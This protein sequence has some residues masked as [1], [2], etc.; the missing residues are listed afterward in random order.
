MLQAAGPSHPAVPRKDRMGC[1]R[2]V[3]KP[4][5]RFAISAPSE[6]WFRGNLSDSE[7]IGIKRCRAEHLRCES[8]SATSFQKIHT[9]SL[10]LSSLINSVRICLAHASLVPVQDATVLL[11]HHVLD[12]AMPPTSH[13]HPSLR[14]LH[15]H[16]AWPGLQQ[17]SLPAVPLVPT[18]MV[19]VVAL[20]ILST[21]LG[22]LDLQ[23]GPDLP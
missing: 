13:L 6:N 4:S 16:S 21:I 10:S 23:R 1:S 2:Y 20:V 3:S 11:S 15:G 8:E 14:S 19:W 18:L 9:S 22:I 17:D 7:F 12:K 5:G